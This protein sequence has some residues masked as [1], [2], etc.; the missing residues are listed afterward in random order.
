MKTTREKL[1]KMASEIRRLADKKI[2]DQKDTFGSGYVHCA[3]LAK[4]ENRRWLDSM[5]DKIY[6]ATKD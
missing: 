1:L 6:E 2:D 3:A 5:I 4:N